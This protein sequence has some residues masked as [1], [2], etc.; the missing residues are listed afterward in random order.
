MKKYIYL[1]IFGAFV[2]SSFGQS[3]NHKKVI[4]E[5]ITYTKLTDLVSDDEKKQ[6]ISWL[7]T[8]EN[9]KK[10]TADRT[11]GFNAIYKFF[12][13]KKQ[14]RVN[15]R[16]I[17]S[18]TN[19]AVASNFKM[20]LPK[21]KEPTPYGAFG[22]VK[23]YGSGSQPLILI[24]PNGHDSRVFN[25]LT[26]AGLD[27]FKTYLVT[28]PGFGGTATYSYEGIT[29]YSD[30]V[31]L[32]SIK[33]ALTKLIEVNKLQQPIIGAADQLVSIALDYAIDHPNKVKGIIAMHAEP[34]NHI[35]SFSTL[36]PDALMKRR[37][38]IVD[39][40]FP[41]G[42][43]SP[44]F[45]IMST[46]NALGL[47]SDIDQANN[48]MK[49]SSEGANATAYYHLRSELSSTDVTLR[50]D[51]L[52]VPVLNIIGNEDTGST[53]FWNPAASAIWQKEV[54]DHP[55]APIYTYYLDNSRDFVFID[56][57]EQVA[58]LIDRFNKDPHSFSN[59]EDNAYK[60]VSNINTASP[61][62]IIQQAIGTNNIEIQYFS[63]SAK[64]RKVFGGMV[65]N[66]RIWMA[67][68]TRT[69]FFSTEKSIQIGDKVLPKGEY[70]LLVVP[71]ENHWTL[72]FNKVLY[73]SQ[74]H[75][76][77]KYDVLRV[78]ID[79]IQTDAPFEESLYYTATS[80]GGK[81][82]EL[83]IH[84]ENTKAVISFENVIEAP[85]APATLN[86]IHWKELLKDDQ[87]DHLIPA[88][89]D[90]KALAYHYDKS[91]DKLWFKFDLHGE[92][93][94]STMA[95]NVLINTGNKNRDF[96]NWTRTNKTFQYDRLVTVWVRE[97]AG[98]YVGW[99]SVGDA[100]SFTLNNYSSISKNSVE[101]YFSGE[102]SFIIGVKRK[103]IDPSLENFDL[104][105]TVG[106]F[107][108]W[109]DDIGDKQHARIELR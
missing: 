83:S 32:K 81:N 8:A 38:S 108:S 109:N 95:I 87:G 96:T 89:S 69:T 34:K 16:N 50:F 88:N 102:S 62:A 11:D 33:K 15:P 97:E 72:V 82:G 70:S 1:C 21:P 74:V 52:R 24:A 94:R 4:E 40:S 30:Q 54:I 9:T 20:G 86:A 63:P 53:S 103:D 105:G 92:I 48:L 68:A 6:L 90:G 79:N 43:L 23:V 36:A 19:R 28:L 47:V 101:Y 37:I 7:K 25:A 58:Q 45:Y 85:E 27:N 106:N 14:S 42:I 55:D 66:D 98:K 93:N 29:A 104:I 5:I 76:E 10:S 64:G 26:Q 77:Q 35:P 80:L 67:G 22:N 51:E 61:K 41:I 65:R 75:Y 2:V 44:D 91:A 60:I 31:W 18:A 99:N 13:Q 78:D 59:I 46:F 39:S 3:R 73:M 12:V 84:W 57:P 17:T 107:I 56:Q 100:K 49:W 71:S